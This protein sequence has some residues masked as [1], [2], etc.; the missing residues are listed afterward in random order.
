MDSIPIEHH[1]AI[2]SDCVPAETLVSVLKSIP[3]IK[4]KHKER[5]TLHGK[6][7]VDVILAEGNLADFI[8]LWRQHFLDTMKPKALPCVWEHSPVIYAKFGLQNPTD[9]EITQAFKQKVQKR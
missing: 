7:M 1:D 3:R 4:L 6:R 9:S 8:R 2:F 5:F